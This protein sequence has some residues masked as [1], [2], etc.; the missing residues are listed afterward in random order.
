ML[1]SVKKFAPVAIAITLLIGTIAPA[2]A[3]GVQ[4]TKCATSGAKK[5]VSKVVYTCTTNPGG[6]IKGLSWTSADC[7]SS[8]KAY[9]MALAQF[10]D[11]DKTQT[12]T[13]TQIKASID[14]WKSVVTILDQKLAE[15]KT[16]SY[17]VDYDHT[18]KPTLPIKVVGIDAAIASITAKVA[19][20]TAKRDNAA[21]QRDAS[22]ALMAAKYTEA[23]I[24]AFA[25]DLSGSIRST[26]V[27]VVNFANWI[28][29]LTGYDAAVSSGQKDISNLQK[30]PANLQDR[31]TK[32]QVQI[33]GMTTRYN[34]AMTNQPTL[35]AQIKSSATQAKSVRGL[36]CKAGL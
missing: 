7:L 33:D 9:T 24:T 25:A 21:K 20:I 17:T 11:F 4:G 3:A 19:A 23:Q 16:T 10:T 12:N 18:V 14:S 34:Q 8:D 32:A 29:A 5:T 6:V 15:T 35:T 31:R 30:I 1:K 13:L 2:S 36:A 26:D 22:K 27:N 28:R